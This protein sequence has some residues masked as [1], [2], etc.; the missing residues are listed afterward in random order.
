MPS[1]KKPPRLR[2]E[3]R[4][5]VLTSGGQPPSVLYHYTSGE[6]LKKIL[7]TKTLL[8]T[9]YGFTNDATELHASHES[10]VESTTSVRDS[11]RANAPWLRTIFDRV[12]EKMESEGFH[13][14]VPNFV[15]CFSEDADNLGQWRAYADDGRGYA[16]GFDTNRW[17]CNESNEPE[18]GT[19]LVQCAYDSAELG[20][21]TCAQQEA[22][23]RRGGELRQHLSSESDRSALDF[24]IEMALFLAGAM[25]TLRLK[26]SGFRDEKEWRLVALPNEAP[27][28]GT[29]AQL[30]GE[31]GGVFVPRVKLN[32]SRNRASLPLRRLMI[33]P[34]LARSNDHWVEHGLRELLRLT[35]NDVNR[36]G[37][38]KRSKVPYRSWR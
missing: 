28:G 8:A 34:T 31:V 24:E 14:D 12:L 33:G 18:F 11:Q 4:E 38:I 3:L 19:I 27:R 2:K 23:I 21:E 30:I 16:I 26:H 5:L 29:G 9:H 17:E 20:R 15:A 1:D 36:P 13:D 25:S 35:G 22:V 10:V 6:S 32:L 37:F 7:E